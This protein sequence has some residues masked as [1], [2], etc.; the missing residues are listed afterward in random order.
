MLFRINRPDARN[1]LNLAVREQ[2]AAGFQAAS[3]SAAA[4]A[5]VICGSA[6]AFAAGTDLKELADLDAVGAFNRRAPELMR[7]I[8]DCRKPVIAAVNGLALGGGFE[9]ALACD[10]LIVGENASLGLPEVKVG[11]MPGGGGTQRLTRLV[12]K[13][14]AML[15]AL[16]G[17]VFSGVE[18]G[19]MGIASLVVP[20]D[21][22]L[23][24]SL[25]VATEIAKLPPIAIQL[26]KDTIKQGADQSLE[27]ALSLERR[28]FQFLFSTT[29]QKEGIA[30]FLEKRPP[31]FRG[32]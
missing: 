13:H 18:A 15:L 28:A 10:I 24:I 32:H 2:L 29:D 22:V 12:G 11:L 5:V 1:A 14:V 19:R 4:K 31:S 6:R 30:A 25:Q 3:D 26:I 17:R 8:T 16:T 9:L 7:P 21:D 20:D 23:A 27:A